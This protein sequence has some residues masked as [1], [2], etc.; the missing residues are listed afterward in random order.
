MEKDEGKTG[1]LIVECEGDAVDVGL[2]G[3]FRSRLLPSYRR[4]AAGSRGRLRSCQA[5]YTIPA[6]L[7]E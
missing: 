4:L 1:P 6:I 7:K 5:T 2:H 3:L